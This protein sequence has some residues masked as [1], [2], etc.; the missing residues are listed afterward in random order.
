M[1]KLKN[2]WIH[3]HIIST[4]LNYYY[5]YIGPAIL[6]IRKYNFDYHNILFPK[7]INVINYPPAIGILCKDNV[8]VIN[9]ELFI[10][11][12]SKGAIS[13]V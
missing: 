12:V 9:N 5:D 8:A 13:Y 7:K 3:K 6:R 10:N 4:N 11:L 2:I 1:N